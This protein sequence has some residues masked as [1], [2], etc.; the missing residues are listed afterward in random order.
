MRQ[1]FGG[2]IGFIFLEARGLGEVW[3]SGVSKGE[4]GRDTIV[5]KVFD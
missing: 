4:G 2:H 5:G 3:N 1:E